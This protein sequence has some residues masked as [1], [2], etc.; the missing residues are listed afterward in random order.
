M[1]AKPAPLLDTS[2]V[3]PYDLTT[4]ERI[5]RGKMPTLELINERFARQLRTTMQTVLRSRII[6]VMSQG[7]AI[8]KFQEYLQ[9]LPVP[10]SIHVIKMDP[11]RGSCL[12]VVESKLVFTIIDIMFG[13]SGKEPYKVEGREFSSLENNIIQRIIRKALADFESAWAYIIPLVATFQKTEINPQFCLITLPTD[14]VAVMTFMIETEFAAGKMTVCVPYSVLEPIRD[15]LIGRFPGEQKENELG[16]LSKFQTGLMFASVDVSVE[17]GRVNLTSAEALNLKKGDVIIMDRH[18]FDPLE[19]MIGG[20]RKFKG[21]PGI[22]KG[23]YAVQIT[24]IEIAEEEIDNE[25]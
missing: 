19:I 16:W 13:G 2:G 14:P 10:S 21:M 5:I 24:G 3:V 4:H 20:K 17:I 23:N 8:I 6:N 11:L 7:T 25:G 18:C 15:K 1:P 12:M 9:S 22:H